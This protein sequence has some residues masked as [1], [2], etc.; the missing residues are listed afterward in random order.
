[1]N[2]IIHILD[3]NLVNPIKE[4]KDL[5][6]E[7]VLTSTINLYDKWKD[8]IGAGWY[9][10]DL[11][12]IPANWIKAIDEIL[13]FLSENSTFTIQQIKIKWGGVRF[14]VE[15]KANSAALDLEINEGIVALEER[16]FDQS[17]IY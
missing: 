13:T 16:M 6:T 7:T 14:Y 1:M 8:Y 5:N 17:L 10:F 2:R 9:G 15:Y 3:E 4:Y 12:N 11:G